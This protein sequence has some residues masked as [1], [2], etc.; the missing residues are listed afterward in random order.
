MIKLLFVDF[1]RT[2]ASGSG[3]NIGGEYLGKGNVYKELYP[4]FQAGKLTMEELLIATFSDWKGLKLTDLPEIVESITFSENAEKSLSK[5][6]N[7]GIK[8]VLLSNIP[9]HLG[10]L[11]QDRF[12]FDYISGNVLEVINGVF[13]GKVL[14]FHTHKQA[15]ASKILEVANITADE[16]AMIGD[17]KDD[18]EVFKTIAIGIS[19][20][21]DEAANAAAKYRINNWADLPSLLN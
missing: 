8:T 7:K 15:D 20:S 14:E 13:T 4:R 10:K 16:A 11:I 5:I 6:R 12:G 9:T 17:R 3:C 21:G 19:Y 18:A 2:L 1:S